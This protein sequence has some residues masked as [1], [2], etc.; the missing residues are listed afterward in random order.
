[1]ARFR[2]GRCDCRLIVDGGGILP[3][4]I[5]LAGAPP[6]LRE[7]ALAARLDDEGL[8]PILYGCLLVR[9]PD[10]TVL[11]DAGIGGYEH[12]LGGSGGALESRLDDAGLAR[13]QID[14]VIVTHGHIDHVGG[15][16][17][18]DR[19]RFESA[20]HVLSRVEWEWLEAKDDAPVVHDQLRPL[21]REDILDIVEVPTEVLPGIRLL[22][23][24]G[25]TPGQVAVEIDGPGGALYLADAVVD[26]LAIEHPDWGMAFDDDPAAAVE[27]RVTLLEH[28]SD[29]RRIVAAAHVPGAGRIE[30]AAD[31]FRFVAADPPAD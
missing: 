18:G 7:G 21:D 5:A 17:A 16:C 14:V 6:H 15:L 13:D 27:T 9:G 10:A 29:E 19:P 25:H 2:A 26:E 8:V 12:P 23:A 22:P 11:V 31:G 1:M 3:P 24:P 20:R 28:A 30:R 4:E